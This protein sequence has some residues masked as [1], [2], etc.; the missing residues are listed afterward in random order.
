MRNASGHQLRWLNLYI[1]DEAANYD[2]P[3]GLNF[4][5][6]V[7]SKHRHLL[8]LHFTVFFFTR[9]V[10]MVNFIEDGKTLSRLQSDKASNT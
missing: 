1:R 8:K 10:I 3:I 5:F 2:D 9:K 6:R 7:R 4:F